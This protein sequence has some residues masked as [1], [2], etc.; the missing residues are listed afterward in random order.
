MGKLSGG[1]GSEVKQIVFLYMSFNRQ[2][3]TDG[4]KLTLLQFHTLKIQLN[5]AISSDRLL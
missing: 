2:T 4:P 5:T 1:D 3:M